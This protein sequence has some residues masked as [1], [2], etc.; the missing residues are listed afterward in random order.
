M[1]RSV[2]ETKKLDKINYL[3]FEFVNFYLLFGGIILRK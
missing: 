2:F 3:V 1:E